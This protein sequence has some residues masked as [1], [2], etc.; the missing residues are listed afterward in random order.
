MDDSLAQARERRA[1]L[2]A[3][4]EQVE[5]SLARPAGERAAQWASALREQLELLSDALERHVVA[6]E[7]DGG[8]LANIV[9]EA[10]RLAHRVDKMRRE[11]VDL[12][13]QVDELLSGLHAEAITADAVDATRERVVTL[14]SGLARHRQQGADLVYEAYNVDIEAAD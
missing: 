1:G 13:S 2:R 6:T 11:H 8:L 10:P 5:R 9:D 7:G 12:R 3:A 4:I 14:L